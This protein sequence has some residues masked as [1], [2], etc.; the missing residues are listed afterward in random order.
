MA[1]R[2]I[3]VLGGAIL[4]CVHSALAAS[5]EYQ[6]T[7]NGKTLVWNSE[8]KS[9]DVASWSGSKDAEGY[10]KGFGTLTWYRT[11]GGKSVVY[12]EYFGNMVRGKLDGPVNAHSKGKTAHAYFTDG[13]RTSP[14]ASGAAPSRRPDVPGADFRSKKREIAAA[15]EESARELERSKPEKAAKPPPASTA[16]REEAVRPTGI[17]RESSPPKTTAR[18][19]PKV[20]EPKPT[21]APS[22]TPAEVV[23]KTPEPSASPVEVTEKTPELMA[24]PAEVAEKTPEATATPMEAAE[25]RPEP[26]ASPVEVA[27]KKPEPAATPVAVAEKTPEPKVAKA[28][29]KPTP[30]AR[31]SATPKQIAKVPPATS[32]YPKT[33][34]DDS[35]R[36]LVGPP[37]SLRNKPAESSTGTN[38][39][40]EA[41]DR[42]PGAAALSEDEAISVANE[43]MKKQGY[44]T[45]H[46]GPPK[47][48]YSL[49]KEQWSVFYR[50]KASDPAEGDTHSIVVGVEDKTRKAAVRP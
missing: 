16:K 39:G 31:S 44:N 11:R 41:E 4:I 9:G 45:D 37:S 24:T 8:P 6:R 48:D 17:E 26:I 34:F 29:S 40:S 18:P 19:A 50:A 35:L 25:K 47:A 46:Y 2:R 28:K 49:V 21:A 22:M 12:A 20:A 30:K 5:G 27:E 32:A 42:A 13:S 43:E 15:E 1:K 33:K 14:W 7:K 23:D 36:A 10:A 3:L 38:P